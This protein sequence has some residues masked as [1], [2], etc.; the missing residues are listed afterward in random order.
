MGDT[1][2]LLLLPGE[3]SLDTDS[4]VG[5]TFLIMLSIP[6]IM[7]EAVVAALKCGRISGALSIAIS[8]SVLIRATGVRGSVLCLVVR[9][10]S[11]SGVVG[12]VVVCV[13]V[14]DI[15]TVVEV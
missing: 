2:L 8:R 13:V 7:F 1:V 11:C 5:G 6:C 4:L 3:G 9:N 12:R 10:G 14:C 15:S